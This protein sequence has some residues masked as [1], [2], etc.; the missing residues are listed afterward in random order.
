MREFRKSVKKI[1]VFG[2]PGDAFIEPNEFEYVF[3]INRRRPSHG[4]FLTGKVMHEIPKGFLGGVPE[5]AF[6]GAHEAALDHI[7][8]LLFH[9]RDEAIDVAREYP[10][11]AID[12][13]HV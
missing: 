1:S 3:L 7:E 8:F 12:H 11:V 5:A 4:G 9:L 6:L 10:L 13:G 2:G